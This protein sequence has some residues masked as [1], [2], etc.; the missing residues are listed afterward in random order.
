ME[1]REAQSG[2]VGAQ[3][4]R[5]PRLSSDRNIIWPLL[6]ALLGAA[7]WCFPAPPPR[8]DAGV[9]G[10]GGGRYTDKVGFYTVEI[11]AGGQPYRWSSGSAFVQLPYAFD[12]AAVY[13]A[14]LRL[15]SERSDPPPLTLLCNERPLLALTPTAGYRRYTLL[16]PPPRGERELRL[17]LRTAPFLPPENPRPLGAIVSDLSLRPLPSRDL[18]ALPLLAFGPALLLIA[19]RRFGVGRG[20]SLTALLLTLAL[21]IFHVIGRPGPLPFGWMA[22]LALLGA[23]G[24]GLAARGLPQRARAAATLSLAALCTVAAFASRLWTYWLTDDAY[25]SFRY[26]QNLVAGRGLAYNIGERVEGYTNFL[27]TVLAALALW[28]GGDL[29]FLAFLAGAALAIGL[30]LLTYRLG[31][32]LLGPAWGLAA[33]LI[34][35]TSQPLLVYTARGAGLETGLFALLALLGCDAWLRCRA[36]GRR[37]SALAAG[38]WLALATLT[39]PEGALLFGLTFIAAVYPQLAQ[40][41]Q[42]MQDPNGRSATP[43][44]RGVRLPGLRVVAPSRQQLATPAWM[45]GVYLAIVLPWFL[46]RFSYYG[47]LLPNTFYAK[48]GGGLRAALRGLEYAGGFALTL[49]VPFVLL[50]LG[51]FVKRTREPGNEGTRERGSQG[52]RESANQY[53]WSVVAVYTLYIIVVGG[54][55][56]PGYRFFVP[57]V[58][59]LAVLLAAGLAASHAWLHRIA[60]RAATALLAL[61]LAG[62]A[63]LALGSSAS[64]DAIIAGDHESAGIWGEIGAWLATETPPGASVAAMGAGAIAYQSDRVVIDMLG[65]TDRHI[66]H[67]TVAGMGDGTPGH[68]KRDPAYV[69]DERMPTYIPQIW[70]EYFGGPVGLR[71]RYELITIATPYGRELGMWRRK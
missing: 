64:Y 18:G 41:A 49:A 3:P 30:L 44:R 5:F 61:A 28:L 57:L 15:R 43:S 16:L 66:A 59:P 31:A 54:D 45:L 10:D 26:A 69:L 67:M 12:A 63:A 38:C 6:L 40:L 68:E 70:D 42:L 35:A 53:L 65:L 60:P 39:R 62:H 47:D 19:L 2:R 8:Y 21:G 9:T 48:T 24:A 33:A 29:S 7:L 50:V 4:P 1:T 37:G 20:A 34:C 14:D 52:T 27:W 17:G 11:D 51:G 58:P 23:L 32:R 71:S 22:A 56:F 55:H 36:D 46:W 25:I 13:V